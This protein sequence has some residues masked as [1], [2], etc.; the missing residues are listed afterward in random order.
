MTDQLQGALLK[1]ELIA[2]DASRA[3]HEASHE[4]VPTILA[5]TSALSQTGHP[6][7]LAIL[8]MHPVQYHSPLYRA[9]CSDPAFDAEVLYLDRLGLDGAYDMEFRTFV[10]WDLPLLEGHP[11]RFLRNLAWNNTEG[12]LSRIN[13]GLLAALARGRYDA[14]LIQGYSILSFWIALVAAKG[15]GTKVIWRGEVTRRSG[16]DRLTLRNLVRNTIVRTFLGGCDAVMY[17]CSGNREF[18]LRQGQQAE[19]LFPFLCAV[20]NEHFRLAF[21]KAEPEIPALRRGFGIP[22]TDMV[23]LYCGRLTA[24]KRPLD[25]LEGVHRSGVTDVTLLIVGD[26][27]Q[28]EELMARAEALSLRTIHVGFVNQLEISRY[29][30]V[31]DVLCLLSEYDPSPKALN[32]AM[33]CGLVPIVSDRIGTAGDMIL[34]GVTGF[35]VPLGDIDVLAEKLR[36]LADDRERR[37]RMAK[38]AVERV[39]AF[40][41]E[42]NAEALKRA[43]SSVLSRRGRTWFRSRSHD[44]GSTGSGSA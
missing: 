7:R 21:E 3:N 39:A 8:A 28:R 30:T 12:F 1:S 17:T 42:A 37:T 18:L 40:S 33:N 13:P 31:A 2:S 6:I 16:D 32:E 35:E 5:S 20:D 23:V 15:T 26:G 36:L 10:E 29:Y 14:I 44:T 24:R 19:S 43:C 4:Q 11:H 41:F 27:P 34:P 38:A 9:I 25:V 22:E